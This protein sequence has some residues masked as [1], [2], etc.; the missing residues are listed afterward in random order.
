MHPTKFIDNTAVVG[1]VIEH[2]EEVDL[3]K[4]NGLTN[5]CQ[6]QNLLLTSA[7]L[8]AKMHDPWTKCF[9]TAASSIFNMQSPQR[10]R[11]YT[12]STLP[13]TVTAGTMA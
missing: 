3:K 8:M 13:L 6:R 11:L 9:K 5:W 2:N 1:L 7:R 4:V 12:H 10:Q